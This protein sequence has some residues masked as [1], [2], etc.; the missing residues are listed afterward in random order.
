MRAASVYETVIYASDL[1]AAANFYREVLGLKLIRQSDLL[2][3]FECPPGVLL[4]FEPDKA[5]KPGRDVPSH[6]TSGAGH[7]AFSAQYEDFDRW[8][9]HLQ[10]H[11]IE[12]EKEVDW[13]GAHSIYIRDP[14]GNS[15][16]L[17]TP[18]LWG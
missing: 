3:V 12:I 1:E 17:A 15:L 7:I 6:G 14:A 4:I 18:N 5:S 13:G 8:R 16:E 11:G 2:L 9:D 10:K